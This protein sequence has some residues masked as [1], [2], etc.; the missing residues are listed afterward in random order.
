MADGPDGGS[1]ADGLSDGSIAD[2]PDDGSMVDGPDDVSMADGGSENTSA[3]LAKDAPSISLS[4]DSSV[5]FDNLTR[6]RPDSVRGD[7]TMHGC[8]SRLLL[9]L[10]GLWSF[11]ALC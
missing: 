1:I 3:I 6:V 8:V 2:G 10:L 9:L 11:A 4:G 5:A 7:G